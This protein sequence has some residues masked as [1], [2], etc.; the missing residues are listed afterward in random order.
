MIDIQGLTKIYGS[1]HALDNVSFRIEPGSVFGLLGPNGSGKSTLLHIIM[2]ICQPSSGHVVVDTDR[3]DA[4]QHIAWLPQRRIPYSG[5]TVRDFCLFN[6]SFFEDADA[7]KAISIA[8]DYGIDSKA[9]VK[10]L[11]QGNQTKVFLAMAL[12]RRPNWFLFDEP[13]S[14][15]D[16]QSH[17]AVLSH[18]ANA[19]GEGRGGAILST[20]RIE[21]VERICD[22]IGILH[23]GRLVLSG[24]ID[25]LLES[26]RSVTVWTSSVADRWTEHPS[27]HSVE[28][29]DVSVRLITDDYRAFVS[30]LGEQLEADVHPVSLTDIYLTLTRNKVAA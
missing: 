1:L 22:T 20:H 17:S 27:I 8:A 13:F 3:N 15:L 9:R 5:Y 19:T 23:K 2:G 28:S 12:A 24:A 30:E 26:W 14:G 7:Q 4:R 29:S 16:K 25:D 10:S 11:S 18:L 21:S 6:A